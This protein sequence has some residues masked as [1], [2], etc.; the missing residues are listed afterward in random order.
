MS[1][2][3]SPIHDDH[4]SGPLS[5]THE[6]NPGGTEFLL[7]SGNGSS[8]SSSQTKG[9]KIKTAFDVSLRKESGDSN[10][11]YIPAVPRTTFKT[12][13]H[14]SDADSIDLDSIDLSDMYNEWLDPMSPQNRGIFTSYFAVGFV[15]YF[16]LTPL[17]Y[18][19]V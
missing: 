3:S 12:T 14:K 19:M 9:I 11:I 10:G 18:Y 6:T 8:I 16:L 5:L 7:G 1:N 15:N 4:A 2:Q 17:V 13:Q